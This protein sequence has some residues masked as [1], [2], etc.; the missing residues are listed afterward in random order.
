MDDTS[1]EMLALPSK[2]TQSS[3]MGHAPLK[4]QALPF[5]VFVSYSSNDLATVERIR[6]ALLPTGAEVFVE[7]HS[8]R[9]GESLKQKITAALDGCDLFILLWSKHAADSDWV[10]MELGHALGGHKRVIPVV[11]DKE[12]RLP[13]LVADLKYVRA[14]GREAEGIA[15]LS[16]QVAELFDTKRRDR[17]ED[18]QRSMA[19]ML[20]VI[21]VLFL[22]A[23]ESK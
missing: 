14:H 22:A 4:R 17:A 11:L 20:L 1:G 15:E 12:A 13:P 3:D 9:P 16:R 18:E 23:A 6:A 7:E 2:A 10:T 8:V 19:V 5:R 21:G